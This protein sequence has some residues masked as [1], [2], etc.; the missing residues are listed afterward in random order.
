MLY[1]GL[2][3]FTPYLVLHLMDAFLRNRRAVSQSE[4]RWRVLT[5]AGHAGLFGFLCA[6][7]P[8]PLGWPIYGILVGVAVLSRLLA[9]SDPEAVVG[10][11]ERFRHGLLQTLQAPL[12]LLTASLWWLIDGAGIILNWM[13]PFSTRNVRPLLQSTALVWAAVFLI[14]VSLAIVARR[15][16]AAA[17]KVVMGPPA[18]TDLTATQ[19][20]P[21]AS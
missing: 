1:I 3:L 13:L 11:A 21:K 18:P 5:A 9:N 10:G 14:E 20:I 6:L 7:A 16:A 17:R 19:E 2:A 12:W 8:G 15:R 4:S